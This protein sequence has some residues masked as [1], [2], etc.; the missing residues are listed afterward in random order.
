VAYYGA[1]PQGGGRQLKWVDVDSNTISSAAYSR[2][3][4]E[5]YIKYNSGSVYKYK[6]VPLVKYKN[7]LYASSSGTYLRN[8]IVKTHEEEKV[9]ANGPG[10]GDS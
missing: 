1:S 4:F 8:N 3:T 5:L 2:D 10:L 9:D 6:N 7:L